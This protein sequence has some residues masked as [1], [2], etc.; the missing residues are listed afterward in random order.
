MAATHPEVTFVILPALDLDKLREAR[1]LVDKAVKMH[2]VFSIQGRYPVIREGLRARGW[3]E[4]CIVSKHRVRRH[5]SSRN[6]TGSNYAVCSDRDDGELEAWLIQKTNRGYLCTHHHFINIWLFFSDNSNDA[7]KDS[8]LVWNEM[9]YFYWTNRRK[10]INTKNLH[11]EQITNHFSKACNLTTKTGLCLNLRKLHWFDSA[12]PDT[13][14][15]RCYRLAALDERHAFIDRD[16][17]PWLLEINSSPTMA[18]STPVTAHLCAAVQ[19]DTLRVVL[20]RRVKRTANTGDFQLIYKKV[21][22]SF[23]FVMLYVYLNGDNDGVLQMSFFIFR[24]L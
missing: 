24:Q 15:P 23:P 8:R 7:E 21:R 19:E 10:A 9:V 22:N 16:L 3:V 4:R 17:H 18:P 6:R 12:D 11:K 14:F 5:Q 1:V 2:K 20:D 13:F